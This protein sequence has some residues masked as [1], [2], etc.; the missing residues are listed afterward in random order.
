MRSLIAI[1]NAI[2]ASAVELKATRKNGNLIA[3]LSQEIKDKMK[4][5]IRIYQNMT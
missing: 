5:N 4:H 3:Q 2:A 1:T